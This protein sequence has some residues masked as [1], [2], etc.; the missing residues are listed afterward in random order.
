M[1]LEEWEKNEDGSVSDIAWNIALPELEGVIEPILLGRRSKQG[2][3]NYEN[4]L[5]SVAKNWCIV[6]PNGLLFGKRE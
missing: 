3:S 4:R 5:K 6:Y 1:T 2:R